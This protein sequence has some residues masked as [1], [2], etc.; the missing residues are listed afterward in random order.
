LPSKSTSTP[1]CTRRGVKK[2]KP[3]KPALST[4][5]GVGYNSGSNGYDAYYEA[6]DTDF[7]DML[8]DEASDFDD[9][10]STAMPMPMPMPAFYGQYV[11]PSYMAREQ[12]VKVKEEKTK[13]QDQLLIDTLKLLITFLPGVGSPSGPIEEIRLYRLSFLFDK[14]AEL[15]RNDSII[16]ITQRKDLYT[17][18]F[19]FV[20]VSPVTIHGAHLWVLIGLDRLLQVLQTSL[21]F[22]WKSAPIKV[23]ALASTVSKI[24]RKDQDLFLKVFKVVQVSRPFFHYLVLDARPGRFRASSDT[25]YKKSMLQHGPSAFSS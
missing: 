4:Q 7:G 3:K 17:E 11:P 22:Y 6:F 1:A 14:I 9:F 21:D 8:V 24:R 2:P 16:D 12:N 15:L 20:Q 23:I 25:L 5:S 13:S 18:V 19:N 10:S